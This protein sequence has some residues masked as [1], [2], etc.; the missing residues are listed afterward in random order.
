[1]AGL[2]LSHLNL[3]FTPCFHRQFNA[4]LQDL[5]EAIK[6]APNNR[7]LRRLFVRVKEEC[8]EHAQ[9][10]NMGSLTSINELGALSTP[11]PAGSLNTPPDVVPADFDSRSPP[12]GAPVTPLP[13]RKREETA[14]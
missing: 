13:E 5:T 7:E 1:M 4:A 6:L 11:P 2:K 9:L 12:L 8:S 3:Y 10:E 14:L